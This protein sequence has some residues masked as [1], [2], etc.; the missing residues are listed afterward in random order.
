MLEVEYFP[1]VSEAS[2]LCMQALDKNAPWL[3]HH[4]T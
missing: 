3:G 4:V 1:V 2:M